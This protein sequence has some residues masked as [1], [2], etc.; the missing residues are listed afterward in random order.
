MQTSF[1]ILHKRPEGMDYETYKE[2]RRATNKAVRAY[3]KG[4]KDEKQGRHSTRYNTIKQLEKYMLHGWS[5]LAPNE[6]KFMELL[7]ETN[8]HERRKDTPG[9]DLPPGGDGS[10]PVPA[11]DAQPVVTEGEGGGVPDNELQTDSEH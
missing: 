3:L 1:N 6:N 5:E 2:E 11:S 10:E 8:E 9:D 4:Q 7:R